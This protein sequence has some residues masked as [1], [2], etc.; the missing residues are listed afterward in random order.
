MVT[1][2]V[3]L[4]VPTITVPNPRESGV[5]AMS[6]RGGANAAE[7]ERS[8]VIVTA[9]G[10]PPA[11]AHAPPHA[12]RAPRLGVSVTVLPVAKLA[13]HVPAVQAIPAGVLVTAP[14]P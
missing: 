6:G 14:A 13:V 2:L 11:P 8:A 5:T 9:Q 1:L 12:V 4:V 3:T 7:A 10:P